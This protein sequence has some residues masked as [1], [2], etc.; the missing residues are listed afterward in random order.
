MSRYLQKEINCK[1]MIVTIYLR[2]N[3]LAPITKA[4][5]ETL[6]IGNILQLAPLSSIRKDIVRASQSSH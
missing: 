3:N 5:V 6:I 4:I 1:D 2:A